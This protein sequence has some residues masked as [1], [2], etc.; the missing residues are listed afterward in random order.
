MTRLW[1]LGTEEN[2][3]ILHRRS[4]LGS[5]TIDWSKICKQNITQQTAPGGGQQ[6]TIMVDKSEMQATHAAVQPWE[7]SFEMQ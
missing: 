3:V 4:S 7:A 6:F 1:E 5:N 2:S